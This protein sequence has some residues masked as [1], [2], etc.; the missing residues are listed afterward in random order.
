[1]HTLIHHPNHEA[2][3]SLLGQAEET[4]PLLERLHSRIPMNPASFPMVRADGLRVASVKILIYG[5]SGVLSIFF[6]PSKAGIELTW[7]HLRRDPMCVAA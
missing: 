3:L 6:S 1:M 4:N 2:S 7:T 5:M